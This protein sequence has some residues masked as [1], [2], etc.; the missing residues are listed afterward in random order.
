MKE[1]EKMSNEQSD[2]EYEECID[3]TDSI[4][5]EEDKIPL[6]PNIKI[7]HNDGTEN[8]LVWDRFNI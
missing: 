5:L 8:L 7:L 3:Y 1:L 4:D 6:N 2:I